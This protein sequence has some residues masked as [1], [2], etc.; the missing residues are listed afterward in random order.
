MALAMMER[1]VERS[2]HMRVAQSV[3]RL[4]PRHGYW[5]TIPLVPFS[6]GYAPILLI[7]IARSPENPSLSIPRRSLRLTE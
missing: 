4:S 2:C 5:Q 7:C 3:G 6:I 1:T